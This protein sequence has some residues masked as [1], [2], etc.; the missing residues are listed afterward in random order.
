ML[1]QTGTRSQCQW[2]QHISAMELKPA[3]RHMSMVRMLATAGSGNLMSS[4]S[5]TV[6]ETDLD[7]SFRDIFISDNQDLVRR[8]IH[9]LA[10]ICCGEEREKVIIALRSLLETS[11]DEWRRYRA[12]EGLCKFIY[13]NSIPLF[14]KI[15]SDRNQPT[16]IRLLAGRA[17]LE[18]DKAQR[19]NGVETFKTRAAVVALKFL[20]NSP[21]D[22]SGVQNK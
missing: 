7:D 14:T 9:L 5:S 1:R 16:R 3:A 10:T 12:I 20:F 21:I 2:A 19:E 13:R 8:M 22:P 18:I 6:A 17:L 11:H 15:W 4:G